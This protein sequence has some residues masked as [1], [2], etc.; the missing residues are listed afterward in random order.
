MF[1]FCLCSTLHGG[2]RLITEIQ[3]ALRRECSEFHTHNV[4]VE[5]IVSAQRLLII[6]DVK[7]HFM[8][9]YASNNVC[10]CAIFSFSVVLLKL[11]QTSIDHNASEHDKN[12]Q[13]FPM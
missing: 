7:S 11:E 8:G 5:L 9:Y 10:H 1:E 6:S 2:K 4:D 12:L 13:S 3:I